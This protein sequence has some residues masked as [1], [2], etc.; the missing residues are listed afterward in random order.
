[1]LLNDAQVWAAQL[2]NTIRY[3]LEVAGMVK[4]G[5]LLRSIKT[6]VSQDGG[7]VVFRTS[8]EDYGVVLDKRFPFLSESVE[9]FEAHVDQYLEESVWN[10]IEQI[11]GKDNK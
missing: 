8:M 10:D 11:V 6:E 9:E 7:D 3:K 1:M 4:S 2:D 5:R